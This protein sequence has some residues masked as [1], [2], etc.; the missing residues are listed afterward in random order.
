MRGPRALRARRACER[1][2]GARRSAIVGY[3]GG[4]VTARKKRLFD[5]RG[6]IE[7]ERD[8]L[9]AQL[10][11]T[12]EALYSFQ[13]RAKRFDDDVLLADELVDDEPQ[14]AH[15]DPDHDGIGTRQRRLGARKAKEL[16]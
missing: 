10:G 16:L 1:A 14:A 12:R 3:S 8:A 9:I 6:R 7:H 4:G 2:S 11:G 5:E 13:R 15:P